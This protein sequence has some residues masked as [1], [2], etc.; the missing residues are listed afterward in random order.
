MIFAGLVII[1]FFFIPVL[2]VNFVRAEDQDQVL[3][4]AVQMRDI[5]E[6]RLLLKNGADPNSKDEIGQTVLMNA[7]MKGYYDVAELLFKNGANVNAKDDVGGTA[8]MYAG[9]G[10]YEDVVGL[11]LDN[12]VKV[13]VRDVMKNTALIRVAARGHEDVAKLLL[14]KGA[15]VNTKGAYGMTPLMWVASQGDIVFVQLL[16]SYGAD[17]NATA[18]DGIT[19]LMVAAG[20][21]YIEEKGQYG[22]TISVSM[23]GG[24]E[25]ILKLLLD[26]DADVNAKDVHGNTALFYAIQ[27]GDNIIKS[28]LLSYGAK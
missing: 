18:K 11:L 15:D 16:L 6:I 1:P 12:G 14:E 22:S 8:L 2:L 21:V 7:C 20:P 13:N 10:G 27:K 5:S 25:K 3:F 17:V 23:E 4:K 24:Y 19:A 26:S 9:M 28:L